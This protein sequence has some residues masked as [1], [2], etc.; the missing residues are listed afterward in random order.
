MNTSKIVLKGG[1]HAPELYTS[2][3]GGQYAPE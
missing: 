3:L 2:H 1:Q